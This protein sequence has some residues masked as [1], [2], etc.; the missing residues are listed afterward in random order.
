MS[1]YIASLNSGS[2]GNCYYVGNDEE[3]VLIDTGISCRETERRMK[4]LGL[5]MHKVKGIFISHEHGDHVTGLPGISKKFQIPVYI[6]PATLRAAALPVEPH[7]VNTFVASECITIGGLSITAFTKFHDADDPHSFIITCSGIT[8]G[9][10]TDIGSACTQVVRYFK[11]CHAVFLEANYCR[12]MLMEGSYPYM[13]KKRISG[14][15][16]HLSNTEALNLFLTHR[17]K[18]LSHLILCHL[19]K[20]NNDPALVERLFKEKA[21][22]TS[23]TVASRYEATEVFHIVS[24]IQTASNVVVKKLKP[25]QLQLALFG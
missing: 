2:N 20:N 4:K 12:D 18:Y 13:L 21:G 5:N 17:S 23:I 22:N 14:G 3:A 10:I 8:V 15:Q 19:S 6:T 25:V 9:V 16:G 7:L 24:S 11:Q 1:L